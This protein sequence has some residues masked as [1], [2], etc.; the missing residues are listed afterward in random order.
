[1]SYWF[2]CDR[3]GRFNECSLFDVRN[4]IFSVRCDVL[5]RVA[6]IFLFLI[7]ISFF[8]YLGFLDD[9]TQDEPRFPIPILLVV[10]ALVRLACAS[11]AILKDISLVSLQFFV[12]LRQH[13]T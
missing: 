8:P 12:A 6:C 2:A 10:A 11:F 13:V 4:R 9:A 7:T 3:A 5:T 1:M